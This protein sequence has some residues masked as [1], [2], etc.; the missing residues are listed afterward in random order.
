MVK[1]FARIAAVLVALLIGA[2][3]QAANTQPYDINAILPIT[4]SAAFLGT[5]ESEALTVVEKL[6]NQTGGIRGRS[7]HFV[8]SDDASDPKND[9][10]LITGMTQRQVPVV[11]GP[12]FPQCVRQ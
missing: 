1:S 2:P 7:V 9:V 11:I 4:G 8:V 3:L 12:Q 6:V 10:Q 5:Q